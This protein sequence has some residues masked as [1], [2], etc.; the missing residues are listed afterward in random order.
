MLHLKVSS[1]VWFNITDEHPAWN[2]FYVEK[3]TGLAIFSGHESITYESFTND[4]AGFLADYPSAIEVVFADDAIALLSTST[5]PPAR[6]N[7]GHPIVAPTHI[8]I[9]EAWRMEGVRFTASGQTTT[10]HDYRITKEILMQGA[11]WWT[12]CDSLNDSADFS[13]VDKDNILGLH[14]MYGLPLG[15]PIELTKFVRNYYVPSGHTVGIIQAPTVSPV[16]SGLYVRV[17]YDNN[18]DT[19]AEIGVNYIYYEKT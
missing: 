9:S 5:I 14:T 19:D 1:T 3:D 6:D 8:A 12:Q 11:H 4:I 10:I 15:T 13:V 2:I 18:A 16:V 17:A 7:G